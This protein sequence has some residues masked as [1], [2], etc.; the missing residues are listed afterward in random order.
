MK[1]TMNS[2]KTPKVSLQTLF[3]IPFL[4]IT[5]LSIGLVGYLSNQNGRSAVNDVANQLRNEITTRILDH[6]EVF[7][8]TPQR[9]I[10]QNTSAIQN[11]GVNINDPA[12][13]ESYFSNQIHYFETVTSIYFGY[14]EG[15]MV[16]AG[17][18]GADGSFYITTTEESSD[19]P[20]HKYA[21]T[22]SGE[23]GDTL[24]ALDY[25]DARTRPWFLGAMDKKGPTW[26]DMYILFTG[27]DL[28][29]A[30]SAPVYDKNQ[31]LLGVTSI[32]IFASHIS[33]FLKELKI[34]KTG[35]GFIIE[36]SGLLVASSA[37]EK[38]FTSLDIES[39]LS[40][41]ESQ[42]PIIHSTAEF[43]KAQYGDYDNI[44]QEAHLEYTLNESRFFVQVSRL[45]DAYGIDWLIVV[46]IPEAD[47]M[48]Q[49]QQN[50]LTTLI[51]ISA[52]FV[53]TLIAGIQTARWITI[54]IQNLNKSAQALAQGKWE[55]ETPGT[56]IAEIDNLS[57]SFDTMA[58]QLQ[59][60]L[61]ELQSEVRTRKNTENALR[62]S[63]ERYRLI[64]ERAKDIVWQMNLD[65][66]FTYCSPAIERVFGYTVEE[67]LNI[68]ASDLLT[69]A[70]R[71]LMQTV[72]QNR[73]TNGS[74]HTIQPMHYQMRHK[75][76]HW[77]DVEVV[78]TP[79]VDA[80]GQPSGFIG[81]TRDISQRKRAA[82]ALQESEQRYK[83]LA[84]ELEERVEDRTS[85]L[86]ILV[87]AM[88]GREV[89]M[90]ELKQ[91]II[92]LRAQLKEAGMTPVADD[93]LKGPLD[94]GNH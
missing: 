2:F 70:G 74:E 26:S 51:L 93:P 50:N 45:S 85:E 38:L 79:V 80:S 25:F 84:S 82:E 60:S 39:R 6:L 20:W 21:T 15:G 67:A 56:H 55:P 40:A 68:K 9:I 78:S 64:T 91:V 92:K 41:D 7:L 13:L 69:E 8:E 47:F 57:T 72:I 16:G 52:T 43:L 49:I 76:G 48:G 17:R 22:R 89:R 31:N 24:V 65:T 88:T 32:D 10:Q 71:A 5:T 27:Q 42:I 14:A 77:I 23:R 94:L 58:L 59:Q 54:P 12:I 19:G 44:P 37:D 75:D 4:L 29:I 30:A 35:Q 73:L 11:G 46:V 1:T 83:Q 33:A 86:Q 90:A 81:I 28:A 63:D 36:R 53:I 34:G 61:T 18:E 3:L 62:I 66:Q 87:S